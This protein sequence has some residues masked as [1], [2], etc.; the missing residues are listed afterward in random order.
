M[1]RFSV[2]RQT[3][4]SLGFKFLTQKK[5]PARRGCKKTSLTLC[6]VV[7]LGVVRILLVSGQA[8]LFALR[9]TRVVSELVVSGPAERVAVGAVV[10]GGADEPE[11]VVQ[12]G[13]G[14]DVVAGSPLESGCQGLL[15]CHSA[16]QHI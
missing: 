7:T 16:D 11:L 14:V 6:T 10:V 9:A 8:D 5:V 2:A 4:L 15:Q 3:P 1:N 12:G 13:V